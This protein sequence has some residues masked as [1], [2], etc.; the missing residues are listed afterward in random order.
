[1]EDFCPT[2]SYADIMHNN[3]NSKATMA[4]VIA[5]EYGTPIPGG[6]DVTYSGHIHQYLTDAGIFQK[7]LTSAQKHVIE[8]KD[9]LTKRGINL[10]SI[11]NV[12]YATVQHVVEVIQ[13]RARECTDGTLFMYFCGHGIS[14]TV[15]TEDTDHGLLLLRGVEKLTSEHIDDALRSVNFSGVLIKVLNTCHAGRPDPIAS[16]ASSVQSSSKQGDKFTVPYRVISL[17]SS[18]WKDSQ[19]SKQGVDA[20]Q[21]I[22][23]FIGKDPPAHRWEESLKHFKVCIDGG[24]PAEFCAF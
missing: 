10:T 17:T 11:Q 20:G 4:I 18:A 5:P 9:V 19:S 2:L 1:M 6:C 13:R 23:S 12:E 14:T 22:I 8:L 24:I 21:E 7:S 16:N 3:P 15:T